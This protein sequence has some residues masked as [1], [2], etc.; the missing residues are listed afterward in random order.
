MRLYNRQGNYLGLPSDAGT[1]RG[2]GVPVRQGRPA[3]RG[4]LRPGRVP[5]RH[6]WDRGASQLLVVRRLELA[7]PLLELDVAHVERLVGRGREATGDP[8]ALL[9]VV[10]RQVEDLAAHTDGAGDPAERRTLVGAP[11]PEVEDDIGAEL[12]GPHADLHQLALDQITLVRWV[13]VTEEHELPLVRRQPESRRADLEL[14]R[15][16]RLSGAGKAD[17]EVDGRRSDGRIARLEVVRLELVMDRH[18]SAPG[19]CQVRRH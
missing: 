7:A 3:P 5:R 17:D 12:R 1:G 8:A 18:A 13:L 2:R 10:D 16:S 6:G 15:A 11:E 9:L 14:L 4:P 19:G